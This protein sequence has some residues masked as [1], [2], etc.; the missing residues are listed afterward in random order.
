[1]Q[2]K[3][4]ALRIRWLCGDPVVNSKWELGRAAGYCS[5]CPTT[6]RNWP[7]SQGRAWHWAV[8]RSGF[9]DTRWIFAL[10][11]FACFDLRL[12]EPAFHPFWGSNQKLPAM[13]RLKNA[14]NWLK[15]NLLGWQLSG[16]RR[17]TGH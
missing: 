14:D 12:F 3:E 2:D 10:A 1:M 8:N 7:S 5:V 17:K 11:S 16:H 4:R 13:E 15:K 6:P 9:V